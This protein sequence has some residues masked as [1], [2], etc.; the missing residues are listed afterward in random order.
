MVKLQITDINDNGP[1]FKPEIPVGHIL[2][3]QDP[4]RDVIITLADFTFDLDLPPQ[5]PYVYTLQSHTDTFDVA[6][7]TGQVKSKVKLNR[8]STPEY[9]VTVEVMDSGSPTMTSTL[10]FGVQVDD[11]NDSPSSPRPLD[12]RIYAYQG[13][14]PGGKIADMRPLD[15]DTTGDYVCSLIGGDTSLF[16]V[17]DSCDLHLVQVQDM[18]D[19][20]VTIRGSDGVHAQVQYTGHIAFSRFDENTMMNSIVV[21]LSDVTMER[22]LD[23]SYVGFLAVLNDVFSDASDVVL[24]AMEELRDEKSI[25]LFL[26]VQRTPGSY[27][28]KA[29]VTQRT[30]A[31]EHIIENTAHVKISSVNEDPCAGVPCENGGV[32]NYE[33]TFSDSTSIAAGAN[34]VFTSPTI[35]QEIR[36]TCPDGFQGDK[37]DEPINQC[38]NDPCLN[39]G[40]CLNL[41]PGEYQCNCLPTWSGTHCELDVNE[42]HEGVCRN[43]GTCINTAGSYTCLCPASFTGQRCD[44]ALDPCASD[45]CLNGATCRTTSDGWYTCQCRY[46]D[47]GA[48]C[49]ITS[50]GFQSLSYLEY[51]VSVHS[52]VNFMTVELATTSQDALLLYYPG[53]NGD[54]LALEIVSG[55]VRFSFKMGNDATVRVTVPKDVNDGRWYR[56]EAERTGKVR[57]VYMFDNNSNCCLI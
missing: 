18:D 54:F 19:Q 50:Q 1:Y 57:K 42:C 9:L 36:C 22:F 3:E 53:G 17:P 13:R 31:N 52:Q 51:K 32:C 26:A 29:E 10:T 34:I 5:A 38:E 48:N 2:E 43:G 46:G 11:I 8:E 6:I 47:R 4:Y 40:T 15:P 41:G 56:I 14:F 30:L 35:R 23:D 27:L 12:I 28:S 24:F 16:S 39:G 44:Q 55:R 20:S 25:N 21:V 7:S 33:V 49:E 37:C 45:P